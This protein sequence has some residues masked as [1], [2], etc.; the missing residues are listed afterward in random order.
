MR[1]DKIARNEPDRK[2]R[3]RGSPIATA[4]RGQRARLLPLPSEKEGVIL[5][6]AAKDVP[7]GE[8]VCKADLILGFRDP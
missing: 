4:R 6:M 1:V 5:H 8:A 3:R 7:D 2:M